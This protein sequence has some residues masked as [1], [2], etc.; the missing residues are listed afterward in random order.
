[1]YMEFAVD[2]HD[3]AAKTPILEGVAQRLR[4]Q[5]YSVKTVALFHQ[6]NVLVSGGEIYPLWGS[7]DSTLWAIALLESHLLEAQTACLTHGDD[8]LLYDRHWMT[9]MV[10]LSSPKLS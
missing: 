6:A 8:I 2:G 1:M 10:E 9:V 5:G 7:V 4:L 3:G